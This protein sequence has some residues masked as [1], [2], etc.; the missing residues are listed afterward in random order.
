MKEALIRAYKRK[1]E[2]GCNDILQY[3]VCELAGYY[4]TEYPK[5]YLEVFYRDLSEFRISTTIGLA[6]ENILKRMAEN[7]GL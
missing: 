2:D 5:K 6:T 3:S 4:I 1:K 7:E